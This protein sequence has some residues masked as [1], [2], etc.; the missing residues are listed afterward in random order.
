MFKRH[1]YYVNVEFSSLEQMHIVKWVLGDAIKK[2]QLDQNANKNELMDL[3]L[4]YQ[5]IES[6]IYNYKEDTPNESNVWFTSV[7]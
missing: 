2:L 5:Q 7:R 3:E 1:E 6:L 4:I